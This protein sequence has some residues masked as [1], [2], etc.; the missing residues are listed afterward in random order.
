[1]NWIWPGLI[2]SIFTTGTM[3][4]SPADCAMPTLPSSAGLSGASDAP[5][6]NVAFLICVMPAAEPI[7]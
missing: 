7:G 1:V 5:K 4:R 6:S 2:P 3:P